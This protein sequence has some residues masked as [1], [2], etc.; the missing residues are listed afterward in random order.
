MAVN[1]RWGLSSLFLIIWAIS[2]SVISIAIFSSAPSIRQ[3]IQKD[4][5]NSPITDTD[6]VE[7]NG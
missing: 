6:H 4:F 7:F 1:N 5:L 3:S 2:L